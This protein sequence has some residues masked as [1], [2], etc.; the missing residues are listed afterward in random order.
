MSYR[1]NKSKFD[2][3]LLGLGDDGHTASLFPG[4]EAS[5]LTDKWTTVCKGKGIDRISLTFPV[6]S[7]A[8]KVIFLVSGASKQVALKR[9]LDPSE[10]PSR[11]PARL[12]RPV[13]EI[14]VL[15]DREAAKGLL[16]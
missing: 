8:R 12:V 4:S 7:A 16:V 10:S 9:L 3:I 5:T 2:L 1:I 13:S 15:A 6:L 14:V 11:T